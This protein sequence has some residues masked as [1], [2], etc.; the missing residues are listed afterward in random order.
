MAKKEIVN[1]D[2]FDDEAS[3]NLFKEGFLVALQND[4]LKIKGDKLYMETPEKI[5]VV[6]LYQFAFVW[7]T[8]F[9]HIYGKD[10][11][12]IFQTENLR[13]GMMR[14]LYDWTNPILDKFPVKIV[15]KPK[16]LADL[17]RRINRNEEY[18]ETIKKAAYQEINTLD[19]DLGKKYMD[20][21]VSLGILDLKDKVML[22]YYADYTPEMLEKVFE[23]EDLS[24]QDKINIVSQ[25][26]AL[27]RKKQ[28]LSG[29][30]NKNGY[31]GRIVQLVNLLAVEEI[32]DVFMNKILT[33]EE[34]I[35]T[36]VTRKD[37]LAL[38]Y[39]DLLE[40]LTNRNDSLPQHLK[41]TSRDLLN[42]YGRNLTGNTICKLALYG[43]IEP[44]DLIEVFEI[45]K[46]LR[47]V[48]D[49]KD[50]LEEGELRAFYTPSRIIG[51]KEHQLLTPKFLEIF[52]E[53]Q[54]YKNNPE[55][56]HNQSQQ[57][58]EELKRKKEKDFKQVQDDILY[59]LDIGL[60]DVETTK[61]NVSQDDIESRFMDNELTIDQV[62]RYHQ[63]GLVGDEAISKYYIDEELIEL[64]ETRQIGGNCLK[65]IKNIDLLLQKF[66]D[67]KIAD[68]DFVMLYFSGNLSIN[69]LTD[70][71]ELAEKEVDIANLIDETITYQQIKEL[72]ANYLIDYSSVLR[73]Y[74]QG[75]ISKEQLKEIEHTVSTREFFQE[76]ESGKVYKV[77]TDREGDCTPK[78]PVII[79]ERTAKDF[80]DEIALI[81]E[82]LEKDIEIENYSL[83]QSYNIKGRATSLNQYRIFGN[84]SL[85]GIII[86]QKSK[87]ENAVY[88]MSALQMMYFLKGKE[89]SEGQIEIQNRMK[90]KAYLK[91][92]EG[93]E[94]IEHT[95]YFARNLVEAAARISPKIAEKVK[96]KDGSYIADVDKMVKDMRQRY[97]SDKEKGRN[98]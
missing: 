71:L 2:L 57:L 7:Q 59:F 96:Q 30:K 84:E 78:G 52:L 46:A 66:C 31:N 12:Q 54:D 26:F 87:K 64:Y 83:I 36:K 37:L 42:E 62:L 53:L 50:I 22:G 65:A 27:E 19:L 97:L 61:E 91:T 14:S 3:Q 35:R 20:R 24:D 88:V 89:N 86:L 69:D 38:P 72:F 10:F 70:G 90:D 45:N 51:M 55:Y 77:I 82:L 5:Y 76:L 11:N 34:F 9:E 21:F 43:Y 74:H 8:S 98:D 58:V 39:E 18:R 79:G 13:P 28:E 73:L 47:M 85:D 40:L 60:C 33:E 80:S 23:K 68:Y 6:N 92:I 29:K 15:A 48:S 25:A 44:Q 1:V 32:I 94:V 93:V 95:E 56:Y 49:E 67:G 75:V 16:F 63:M 4:T 41:I 81:S 17:R